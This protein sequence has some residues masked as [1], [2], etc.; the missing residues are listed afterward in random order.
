MGLLHRIAALGILLATLAACSGPATPAPT[1][2]P[3]A[4]PTLTPLPTP[5]PSPVPTATPI[6]PSVLTVL[7]LKQVSALQPLPVQVALKSPS[8]VTTTATI[9]ATV[10]SPDGIPFK[11]FR[12]APQA[13]DLYVSPDALQLPL[14]PMEGEW[15]LVVNVKSAQTIQG[16]R[17]VA[18]RPAPIYFRDLADVLPAAVDMRVPQEF[19]EVTSQG[20]QWAGARVWRYGD[21]QVSVWWAPGPTEPLLL[22]NAVAM[23]EATFPDHN[24]PRVAG[25][26]ETSWQDHTAFLFREE[27]P[28]DKASPAPSPAE[29]LVVQ[30]DDYWLYVVRVQALNGESISPL[31]RQVWQTFTFRK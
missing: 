21:E 20:N 18:F 24:P 14:E 26:R 3:T 22:N 28:H 15:R 7:W 27:W 31:L 25:T 5:L 23:L 30:G 6:P 29:A 13:G 12:L 1:L 4:A 17:Q 9:S 11:T 19:A 10:L 16:Q 2:I 8:G